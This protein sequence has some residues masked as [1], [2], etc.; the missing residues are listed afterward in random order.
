MAN[1][2]NVTGIDSLNDYYNPEIKKVNIAKVLKNKNFTFIHADINCVAEFD[3]WNDFD[4]IFHLAAQPG[5]R[6]SWGNSFEIYV[7]NNISLT[8]KLLESLKYSK[9]LKKFFFASSSSVYGEITSEKV[10][11]MDSVRPHSPYGVTKL[12]AENLC[13]LYRKN[14]NVPTVSLRFFTVYGPRQ[15]PDMAFSRLIKSA[16]MGDLFTVYGD[17]NQLRDYTFVSDIVEGVIKVTL[18][19]NI[20]GI[21]NIAG[22]FVI[23]INEVISLVQKV[24]GKKLNLE[25]NASEKGD[26][27]RTGADTEKIMNDL[28]FSAAVNIVEGITHQYN[29]IIRNTNE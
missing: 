7:R 21:Y 13:E 5:V 15:R 16:I 8:Q 23:S 17:G 22:G 2:F 3:K 28:N 6:N 1:G 4:Y 27:F 9:K 11:E 10:S 26:V 24:T 18:K 12:A 25:Y 29:Y 20:Y 19:E 14:F